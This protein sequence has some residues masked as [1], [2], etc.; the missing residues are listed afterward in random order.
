MKQNHVK[1][2]PTAAYKFIIFFVVV[3]QQREILLS[4]VILWL[5]LEFYELHIKMYKLSKLS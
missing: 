5:K 3:K 2:W 4:M 1:G